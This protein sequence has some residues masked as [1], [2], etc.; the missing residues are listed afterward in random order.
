MEAFRDILAVPF[1]WALSGLYELTH[2][3]LLAL[4]IITIV[5][6]L[7][8]LPSAIKQQKTSAKQMRLQAKVNKIKA[9]YAGQNSR[10]T[11]QKI[12]QE[13]QELY[14][15]EGFG[16]MGSGCLT[17]ALQLIVMMGLYQAIYRPLSHVLHLGKEAIAALG[18][19]YASVMT[20]LNP[21]FAYNANDY[22]LQLNILARFDDVAKAL[23]GV[24]GA[25][26]VSADTLD[27]IRTFAEKFRIFG[28]DLTQ[29]PKDVFKEVGMNV[30]ILIPVIAGLTALLS[31]GYTYLK[32]RKTNPEMAKNPMMGCMTLF[33]PV[34]SVVFAY[35]LPAGIGFYWIISN[36]LSF[37]Q[38]LALNIMYK[39]ADI[40]AAQMIDETVQRRA[41]EKSVK[42]TAA[43]LAAREQQKN[44]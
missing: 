31:A 44:D 43:L 4:V 24:E 14:S 36:I 17:M 15:R 41:R 12:Q 34:I 40:I 19:A 35:T 13:T 32:Q 29:T 6:R 39:P 7:V 1:G 11:Q 20:G 28:I 5:L 22:R 10:E 38:I 27:R 9:K 3:Y 26:S 21:E 25:A 23:P 16:G 2:N 8:L 30:L 18:N 33:S 42:E 37:I